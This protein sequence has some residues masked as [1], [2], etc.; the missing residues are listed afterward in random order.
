[1]GESA[2]FIDY[3]LLQ[4][5]GTLERAR[6]VGQ[7]ASGTVGSASPVPMASNPLASLFPSAG[8]EPT[9]PFGM[10]D[11]M[12]QTSTIAGSASDVSAFAIKLDGVQ[13]KLERLVERLAL[14]EGKLDLLGKP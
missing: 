9:N 8:N 4:K 6:R 7:S 12:A 2:D 11:S 3:T 5:K 14:L 10:L 13:Y 1:M